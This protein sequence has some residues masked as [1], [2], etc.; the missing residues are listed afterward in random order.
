MPLTPRQKRHAM[1]IQI[2]QLKKQLERT[3]KRLSAQEKIRSRVHAQYI[4]EANAR[5]KNPKTTQ[6]LLRQNKKFG[7]V[8]KKHFIQW[9]KLHSLE[10]QLKTK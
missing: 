7:K 6:A 4:V 9:R 1:R 10:Q 3:S 8:D 2:S 5:N